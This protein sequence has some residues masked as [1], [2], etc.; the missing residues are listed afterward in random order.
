MIH[1]K[2]PVVDPSAWQPTPEQIVEHVIT[3]YKGDGRMRTTVREDLG[4]GH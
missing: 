3:D 1:L 4:R 2:T